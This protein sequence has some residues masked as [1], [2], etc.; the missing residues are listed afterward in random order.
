VVRQEPEVLLHKVHFPIADQKTDVV[1]GSENGQVPSQVPSHFTISRDQYTKLSD[2]LTA[3]ELWKS[4]LA[5]PQHPSVPEPVP[6]A[7]FLEYKEATDK[8]LT[9]LAQEL[10]KA[11]TLIA[12]LTNKRKSPECEEENYFNLKF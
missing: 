4:T 7:T 6:L 12:Q 10:A 9:E 1:A 5:V 3:L 11:N 8:Q 2:I